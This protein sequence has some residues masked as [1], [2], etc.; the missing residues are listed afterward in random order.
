MH[1]QIELHR[2]IILYRKNLDNKNREN[3]QSYIDKHP[4]TVILAS[5]IDTEFMRSYG[6]TSQYL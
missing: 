5:V 1:R 6:F 4:V 2:L 3:I